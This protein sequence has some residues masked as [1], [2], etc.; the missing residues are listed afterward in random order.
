MF[1]LIY[2]CLFERVLCVGSRE[3]SR[4]IPLLTVK[5]FLK[6]IGLCLNCIL[7]IKPFHEPYA[8]KVMENL[9]VW[10]VDLPVF[11]SCYF[12]CMPFKFSRAWRLCLHSEYINLLQNSKQTGLMR[13]ASGPFHACTS[14]SGG[15]TAADVPLCP[16]LKDPQR[17]F[18]PARSTRS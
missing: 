13:R 12:S 3:N 17:G 15:V 16:S 6:V 10:G 11:A 14:S 5:R 7:L 4:L 8:D 2:F 18:K 9:H 1:F